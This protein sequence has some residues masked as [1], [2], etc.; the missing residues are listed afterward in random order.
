[1]AKFNLQE[2]FKNL[3]AEEAKAAPRPCPKCGE[4]DADGPCYGYDCSTFDGPDFDCSAEIPQECDTC[5][6]IACEQCRLK[7]VKEILPDHEFTKAVT[8]GRCLKCG[9]PVGDTGCPNVECL[10]QPFRPNGQ[11]IEKEVLFKLIDAANAKWDSAGSNAAM[12]ELMTSIELMLE[13]GE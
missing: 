11:Y 7:L 2:A 1:M 6:Y 10:G 8:G 3:K 4:S 13:K 12:R 9:G 5:L